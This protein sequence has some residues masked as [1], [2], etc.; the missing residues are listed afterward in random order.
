M[1]TAASQVEVRRIQRT[2]KKG[3]KLPPDTLCVTRPGK[4]GNPFTVGLWFRRVTPDWSVW[5]CGDSPQFGSEQ[6][7]DLAHSLGLFE[8]YAKHRMIWD[9]SWLV[10]VRN[11]KFI[12]CWCKVGSTCH[13]DILIKLI[14]ND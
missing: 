13:A 12:A 8:D 9:P 7:R 1:S 14:K 11:A 3:D 4:H 5:T 2:R 6:V 10:P